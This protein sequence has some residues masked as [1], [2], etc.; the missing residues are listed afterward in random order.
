M[1]LNLTWI[2]LD[3]Q[4]NFRKVCKNLDFAELLFKVSAWLSN[5]A[6][7]KIGLTNKFEDLYEMIHLTMYPG[8]RLTALLKPK[9]TFIMN[10]KKC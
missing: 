10:V 9:T 1:F 4:Q 8:F 6:V 7:C 2:F 5:H 3:S